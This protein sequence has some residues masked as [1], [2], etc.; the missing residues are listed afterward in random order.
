MNDFTKEELKIIMMWGQLY[1]S[2]M[3]IA[4]PKLCS[5]KSHDNVIKKIKSMLDN[6]CEHDS[7]EVSA[8]VNYC[9]C[10]D[11]CEFVSF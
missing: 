6:Y 7:H 10:C 9:L 2:G 11:N 4:W 8:L 1:K 5:K 3:G